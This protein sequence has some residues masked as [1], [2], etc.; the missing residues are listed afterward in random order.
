[1][2]P[3]IPK[4]KCVIIDDDA[5]SML[6]IN[7]FCRDIPYMEVVGEFN[8]SLKFIEFLPTLNFDVCIVNLNMPRMNGIKISQQLNGKPVIF[9]AGGDRM[10]RDAINMAPVDI[11]LKPLR[12][13]KINIAMEKAYSL[14]ENKRRTVKKIDWNVKEYGFFHVAGEAGTVRIRLSDILLVVTE[15]VHS[16]CSPCVQ[17]V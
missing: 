2:Q 14:L 16:A 11:V 3:M 5:T 8:D 1:M 17:G 7:E 9:V 6:M 10:L 13:E 12:K 15:A 4:F